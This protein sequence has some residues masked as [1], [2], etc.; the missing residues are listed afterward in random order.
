MKIGEL[1]VWHVL[2]LIASML[3]GSTWRIGVKHRMSGIDATTNAIPVQV[4]RITFEDGSTKKIG[5]NFVTEHV[6]AK[7]QNAFRTNPV[8]FVHWK[9]K[10]YLNPTI[11]IKR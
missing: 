8:A 2:I 11:S 3:I 10:V 9:D 1:K 4:L 5:A 6:N 7:I